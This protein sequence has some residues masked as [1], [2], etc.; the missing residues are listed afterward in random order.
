MDASLVNPRNAAIAM[1]L[2]GGG[3]IGY[4]AIDHMFVEGL[5]D[6]ER[7]GMM[8]AGVSAACLYVAERFGWLDWITV[9]PWSE[10][11][12]VEAKKHF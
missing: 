2:I 8:I 7:K 4:W 10:R 9:G 1:G 3:V 12:V 6:Q 11:V 5:T